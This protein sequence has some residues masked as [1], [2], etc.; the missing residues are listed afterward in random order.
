MVFGQTP[1]SDGVQAFDDFDRDGE[2]HAFDISVKELKKLGWKAG[3][4][5]YAPFSFSLGS[6][7]G[8]RVLL[9]LFSIIKKQILAIL[10]K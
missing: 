10:D 9:T 6:R 7:A 4:I 1:N 8:T 3:V 2:W 5:E